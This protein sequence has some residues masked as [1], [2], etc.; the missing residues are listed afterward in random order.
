MGNH[1]NRN[2]MKMK[3]RKAQSAKK[4]RARHLA[5]LPRDQREARAKAL[6][7][8]PVRK[9]VVAADAPADDAPAQES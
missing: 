8:A 2:S 3:R 1:D 9:P 7:T 6:A 5:A 4:E